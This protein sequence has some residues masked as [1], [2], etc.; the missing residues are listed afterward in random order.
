[1]LRSLGFGISM[2]V[3]L[4]ASSAV[5]QVP[6]QVYNT[7]V[8]DNGSL[9]PIG[10]ADPHYALSAG[11]GTSNTAYASGSYGGVWV[12]NTTTSQWIN[13]SGTCSSDFD[14]GNYTYTTSIPV[15]SGATFGTL[16][17]LW[18]ADDYIE[19]TTIGGALGAQDPGVFF[20][21]NQ[22]H[23]SLTPFSFTFPVDPSWWGTNQPLQ[24]EVYNDVSLT[25]LQVQVSGVW[26]VPEP[27]TIVLLAV[28]TLGLLAYGWR[29]RR[30]TTGCAI[31][32]SRTPCEQL[33][34]VNLGFIALLC[35]FFANGLAHADTVYV[36]T[37]TGDIWQYTSANSGSLFASLS[38][39]NI[40]GIAVDSAGN[41]Y[42]STLTHGT[43]EEYSS[44][45]THLQ[46]F[47]SPDFS[48]PGGLAFD[49]SGNLYVAN[50]G[51]GNNTIWK[52]TPSS[53]GSI[54]A[55][56]AANTYGLAFDSAEN[57]YASEA[58]NNTIQ[59]F[60]SGGGSGSVFA[61]TGL[62]EPVGLAFHNGNL[63]AANT[64]G[65]TI[66]EFTA[67]NV[68]SVFANT[69]LN[70]PMGLAFDSAGDLFVA[71]DGS[72]IITEIMLGGLQSTFASGLD[73]PTCLAI[74]RA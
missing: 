60:P 4:Y 2:V 47:T 46:T 40:G 32:I 74:A 53:V 68:G 5:G 11:I 61:N 3:A 19:S 66:E 30:W 14:N 1:M 26:S 36:G 62:N 73:A 51:Y 44:T 55:Y 18:A 7:G 21:G 57:L 72:G 24:F 41:V 8:Y 34:S 59:I 16:T 70:V 9:I 69:D 50:E 37:D 27:S 35:L 28:G 67:K 49:K 65:N 42:M 71:N 64:E 45:G 31:T 39:E 38:G 33:P 17:G 63:Y 29:R 20:P 6:I 25:G 13:P 43:V 22:D 23:F 48:N 52:I 54:F 10:S 56:T 12:D 15:V 58:L